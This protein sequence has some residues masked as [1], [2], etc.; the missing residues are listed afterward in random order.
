M[1]DFVHGGERRSETSRWKGEKGSERAR[2]RHRRGAGGGEDGRRERQTKRDA[3]LAHGALPW[4]PLLVPPLRLLVSK[5][6][7]GNNG[8]GREKR[9]K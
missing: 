2:E 5:N 7:R 6:E 8:S 1:H 9:Q 4:K 3:L